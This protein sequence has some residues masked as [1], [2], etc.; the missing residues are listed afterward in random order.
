MDLDYYMSLPYR[1]E[2]I[3]DTDEEG[4]V[5]FIP[6]L[7]GCITTGTTEEEALENLKDAKVAW[8][9]SA[10]EYG[11][12]IPEPAGDEDA[13]IESH[14]IDK[15]ALWKSLLGSVPGGDD[16]DVEAVRD[17]RIGV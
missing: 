12:Q 6:E 5:V 8:F 16:V 1:V 4:Y 11:D 2:I 9:S 3:K 17:E 14:E 10:I 7:K 13:S 15:S